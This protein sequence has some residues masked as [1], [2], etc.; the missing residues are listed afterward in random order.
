[1]D[2]VEPPRYLAETYEYLSLCLEPEVQAGDSREYLVTGKQLDVNI[3]ISLSKFIVN[4]SGNLSLADKNAGSHVFA[5]GVIRDL[6]SN[7]LNTK[8]M[9]LG[10][11]EGAIEALN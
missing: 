3:Q 5:N 11:R 8:Y 6:V 9:G 1:L 4:E 7:A 2:K 10:E